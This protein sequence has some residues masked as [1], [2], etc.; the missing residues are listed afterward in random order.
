MARRSDKTNTAT[1]RAD[2]ALAKAVRRRSA[3]HITDLRESAHGSSGTER[4]SRMLAEARRARDAEDDQ[5]V[6][7]E[8]DRPRPARLLSWVP[9]LG[10]LVDHA[11]S[12]ATEAE[13]R[14]GDVT[15]TGATS[16]RD[17]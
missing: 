1:D 11:D 17:P 13:R 15:T 8:P 12:S 16:P 5:P 2:E 14:I 4:I 6:D 9:P 3:Q 10:N 7:R